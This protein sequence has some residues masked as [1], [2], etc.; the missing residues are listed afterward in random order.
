MIYAAHGE[1]LWGKPTTFYVNLTIPAGQSDSYYMEVLLPEA[2]DAP[3]MTF[4]DYE[5]QVY[6]PGFKGYFFTSAFYITNSNT[7]FY[8]AAIDAAGYLAWWSAAP[9]IATD[10]K[11]QPNSQQFSFIKAFGGGVRQHYLMSTDF[12][13]E[14]TVL[15]T[16]DVR[17]DGHEFLVLRNG[18]RLIM[19]MQD[20]SLDLSNYTFNGAPGLSN[21]NVRS[22]GMQ[23]FDPAGNLVML[24]PRDMEPKKI[25]ADIEILFG[26]VKGV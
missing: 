20:T 17:A 4:C 18:N 1:V 2:D 8:I 16:S 10:L 26:R 21:G 7:E 23:E 5:F 14:D 24:Y 13:I 9:E 15:A 22:I 6:S 25:F 11:Y 12:Q 3:V 19:T